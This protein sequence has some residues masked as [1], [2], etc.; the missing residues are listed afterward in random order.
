MASPRLRFSAFGSFWNRVN[1]A[2]L[3]FIAGLGS[4]SSQPQEQATVPVLNTSNTSFKYEVK[5]AINRGLEYLTSAQHEEGWWSTK[6]HPALTALALSAFMGHPDERYKNLPENLRSGY[7]FLIDSVQEDGRIFRDGMANYNT[8]LATMAF[9]LSGDPNY[10]SYVVRARKRLIESQVD[11]GSPGVLDT[12]FDGGVGYNDKY[13]HSDLNNTLVA[14]ETL[15]YTQQSSSENSEPE[16]TL[17]WKAA[18]N[19]IQHCQNLPSHN[20]ESWVSKAAE[21][22]GGFVYLPGES[23]AGERTDPET[24]RVALRSYGSISYAGLLSYI[25]ADLDPKDPRVT[26]ALNWLKQNF[27][28]EENPGMGLEGY[29]YYLHLMAKALG[30]LKI[31]HLVME[32][33]SIVDWRKDLADRLINLQQGDGSWINANGRWWERDPVLVTAYAVMTLEII[34]RRL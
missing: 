1:L 32:D 5:R 25:Y 18:L 34:Y 29:Y 28:L 30:T 17:D 21:D 2:V 14:L 13:E 9:S 23:K 31:N 3:M 33:G 4:G 15:Y 27:T 22:R 16:A 24:G 6:D 7:Q 10:N 12:P 8:A 11:M 26:A 20:D 19:F